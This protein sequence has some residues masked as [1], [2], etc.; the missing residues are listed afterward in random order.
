M[1]FT[2]HFAA[3]WAMIGAVW[4]VL[5][6]HY[7]GFRFLSKED[8]AVYE[9]FHIRRTLALVI[10]V[11]LIEAGTALYL[12]FQGPILILNA[13]ILAFIWAMTFAYCFPIHI[14]LKEKYSECRMKSLI[15]VHGIRV[16]LWTFR[17]VLLFFAKEGVF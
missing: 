7:P 15:Q 2:V 10:P 6:V 17:G 9:S 14:A 11:M 4:F 3:T 1:I 12:M 13:L 5:F 8:F 16:G